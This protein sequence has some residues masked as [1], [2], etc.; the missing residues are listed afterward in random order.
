M[1]QVSPDR[2]RWMVEA[3]IMPRTGVNDPQGEAILSG[4]HSLGFAAASR[5]RCGKL[6]RI[7]IMASSAEDASRQ[8]IE[9]CERLLANPVIEEFAVT[10]TL[11]AG[12][13]VTS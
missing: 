4:L 9:M 1:S 6:L 5:V 7:E 10:A 12:T 8:G 13:G 11:V 3:E 2:Q